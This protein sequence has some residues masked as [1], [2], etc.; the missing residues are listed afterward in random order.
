MT[1]PTAAVQSKRGADSILRPLLFAV[2]LG[3]IGAVI[4]LYAIPYLPKIHL[5]LGNAVYVI[6]AMRLRPVFALIT[7]LIATTPLH[8]LWGI[9]YGY[10]IFGLEAL[11]IAYL[12]SIGWYVLFADLVYWLFIGIPLTAAIIWFGLPDP[13][14]YMTFAVVKQGFNG[15]LYTSI[16]CLLVF[17]LGDSLR[18]NQ[19]FAQPQFTR[20]LK[21]FLAHAI[22]LITS[23][24]LVAATQLGGKKMIDTEIDLMQKTLTD[25][26]RSIADTINLFIK[27]HQNVIDLAA[28]L[29]TEQAFKPETILTD[30]HRHASDFETMLITD[31]QGNIQYASPIELLS[32]VKQSK[33][34]TDHNVA[35]RDYFQQAMKQQQVYTLSLIHI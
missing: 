28:T 4:N 7:A 34:L 29:L 1:K 2:I 24:S 11:F 6:V 5:V 22:L 20:G 13:T 19:R 32:I 17:F 33:Q 8:F 30:I 15:I 23:L 16:G 31:E 18:F 25:S 14:H 27:H 3:V 10:L 12:R 9:G 35:D 26:S 21:S